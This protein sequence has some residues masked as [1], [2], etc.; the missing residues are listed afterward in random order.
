MTMMYDSVTITMQP[1]HMY[2]F[3]AAVECTRRRPIEGR[4]AELTRRRP[5]EGRVEMLRTILGHR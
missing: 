1:T 2:V 3:T 5:V 4:V